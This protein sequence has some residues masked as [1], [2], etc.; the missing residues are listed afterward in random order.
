MNLS[1]SSDGEARN[2]YRIFVLCKAVTCRGYGIITGHAVALS[3]EALRYKPEG[4]GFESR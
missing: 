4:R 3:V 1:C 2:A